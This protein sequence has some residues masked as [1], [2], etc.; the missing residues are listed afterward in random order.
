M[1]ISKLAHVA[2]DVIS[3]YREGV[4]AAE[5]ARRNDVTTTTVTSLL[6][7]HGVMPQLKR[8]DRDKNIEADRIRVIELFKEGKT[9]SE[10][11][12][13]TGRSKSCVY[14][15]LNN[16][17]ADLR[18]HVGWVA[19]KETKIKKAQTAQSKGKLNSTEKFVF[20]ALKNKG[21]YEVFP[22]LAVDIYNIDLAIHKASIAIEIICRGSLPRYVKTGLLAEKIKKL[23][24]LGWHTYALIALG[25]KEIVDGGTDDLLAWIQF[26][27]RQ[28]APRRQYRVIRSPFNLLAAGCSDDPELARVISPENILQFTR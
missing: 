28:K 10:I 18:G 24:E 20:D 17:G 15:I 6:K 23:S 2:N 5:I 22:Q 7:K 16:S 26:M 27:E 11:G 9:P 14:A 8:G 25:H 3:L 13:I 1:T 19:P 4:S 21:G 12:R